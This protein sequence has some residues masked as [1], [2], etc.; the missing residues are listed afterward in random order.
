M[1]KKIHLLLLAILLPM[2]VL[3]ANDILNNDSDDV[4]PITKNVDF[5][6]SRTT[7]APSTVPAEDATGAPYNSL[8][9]EIGL[10]RLKLFGYA[11]SLY[12]YNRTNGVDKNALDV[13][14]VILMADAHIAKRLSFFMMFDVVK[15]EMHE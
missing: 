7:Y 10:S 8:N 3:L 12:Y 9:L 11:Q 2:N 15:S 5:A 4:A 1:I 14:R 6:L 13:Q